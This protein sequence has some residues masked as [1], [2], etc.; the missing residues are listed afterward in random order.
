M[1]LEISSLPRSA[2]YERILGLA[3]DGAFL[4]AHGSILIHGH[5][6]SP[7]ERDELMALIAFQ[8]G[9]LRVSRAATRFECL[10]AHLLV[11]SSLFRL[12][13]GLLLRAF[14]LFIQPFYSSRRLFQAAYERMA[15][16]LIHYRYSNFT[17][18]LLDSFVLRHLASAADC[19]LE[20]GCVNVKAKTTERLGF[21]GRGEGIAADAVALLEKS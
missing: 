17:L 13:S 18:G 5:L 10:L 14:S 16:E 8:S 7:L 9:S 6:L 20:V 2:E 21:T 11:R 19:G 1:K 12:V 3:L 15:P 4:D